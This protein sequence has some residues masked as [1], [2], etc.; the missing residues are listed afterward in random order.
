MLSRWTERT[1]KRESLDEIFA[2]LLSAQMKSSSLRQ[3]HGNYI[4]EYGADTLSTIYTSI[5]K[6]YINHQIWAEWAGLRYMMRL[7]N[8]QR[9]LVV[10]AVAAQNKKKRVKCEK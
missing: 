3:Q 10:E 7:Q 8:W 9:L 1:R 4:C 2:G 6:Y 5:S